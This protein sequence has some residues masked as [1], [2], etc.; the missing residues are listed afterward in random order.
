MS[1]IIDESGAGSAF[2]SAKYRQV[3]G[4]FP[5]GVTVITAMADGFEMPIVDVVPAISI[6]NSTYASTS[7]KLALTA[8]D[9][10]LVA[11]RYIGSLRHS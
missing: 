4:H 2:D 6:F 10:G 9:C 8:R 11:A 7:Q 3:L 1:D 5:T